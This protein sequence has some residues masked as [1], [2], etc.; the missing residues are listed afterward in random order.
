MTNRGEL[1]LVLLVGIAS[2]IAE[3]TATA[4]ELPKDVAE[5]RGRRKFYKFLFK[6][7]KA[8]QSVSRKDFI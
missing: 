7:C 4:Q 1:L 6:A 8:T 3:E 2:V 5:A